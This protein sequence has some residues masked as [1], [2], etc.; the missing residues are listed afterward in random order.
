MP[1]HR[2]WTAL[3]LPLTVACGIATST[4]AEP[5]KPTLLDMQV[6]AMPEVDPQAPVIEQLDIKASRNHA[7]PKAFYSIAVRGTLARP[8]GLDHAYGPLA[9]AVTA[10]HDADD[11]PMRYNTD[12]YPTPDAL[13]NEPVDEL[14]RRLGPTMVRVDSQRLTFNV[15]LRDL[16]YLTPRFARL[17]IRSYAI[18]ADDEQTLDLDLPA[19]GGSADVAGAWVLTVQPTEDRQELQLHSVNP[20]PGVWPLRLELIDAEDNVVSTGYRRGTITLDDTMATQWRFSQPTI[21]PGPDEEA[22]GWRLRVHHTTNLHL[23]QLDA[24]L[25]DVQ[26]IDLTAPATPDAS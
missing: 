8:D 14:Y 15:L 19:V 26:L 12:G 23:K 22:T 13:L 1:H 20:E 10:A 6:E 25:G 2:S 9:W 7:N 21:V 24:V 4:V 17:A 3:V 18:L 16:D 11:Q 5:E